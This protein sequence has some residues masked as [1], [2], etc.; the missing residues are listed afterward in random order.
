MLILCENYDLRMNKCLCHFDVLQ[1]IVKKNPW[2]MAET[3]A[4]MRR[5]CG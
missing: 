5:S 3:N 2:N 4:E 1:K